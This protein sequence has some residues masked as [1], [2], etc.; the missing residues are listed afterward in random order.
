MSLS[1]KWAIEGNKKDYRMKESPDIAI[2][3]KGLRLSRAK[4]HY[5]GK[6]YSCY[7]TI[8]LY[9]KQEQSIEDYSSLLTHEFLHYLIYKIHNFS[10]GGYI[11]M[12]MLDNGNIWKLIEYLGGV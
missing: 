4:R 10:L 12:Q 8:V 3:V 2:K 6:Y 7:H 11:T 5:G 9:G 1:I